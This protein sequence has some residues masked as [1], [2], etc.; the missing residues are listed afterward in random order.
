MFCILIV[1]IPELPIAWRTRSPKNE[2][3]VI[4]SL[5]MTLFPPV[6]A[7]GEVLKNVNAVLFLQT[8]KVY[9]GKGM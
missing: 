7:K 9:E 4:Y 1:T 5:H 3:S 6:N 8:K 2:N